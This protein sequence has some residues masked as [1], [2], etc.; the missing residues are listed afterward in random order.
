MGQRAVTTM[1]VDEF[2]L[3][4]EAQDGLYELVDGYPLQMMSG[5]KRRHDK[6]TVSLVVALDRK[7]QGKSCQPTTQDTGIKISPTQLR[8]PEVM[9][10]CGN[11]SDESF[12]ASDP[13][14]VFE[15][16]SRSTRQFDLT[17]KLEEYKTV[18]SLSHIVMIDPD[19]PEII[20]FRQETDREWVSEIF[21]GLN[22]EIEFASLGIKLSLAEIYRG[23]AFRPRPVLVIEE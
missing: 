10:D 2:F 18:E 6:I 20:V 1:T 21:T 15:V 7:L 13:R 23:L 11:T 8:R 9:I 4:Q 16:L 22:T 19:N 14:V 5:A 3:W 12:I 17:K